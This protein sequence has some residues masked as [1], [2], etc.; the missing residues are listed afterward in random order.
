[1]AMPNDAGEH[2][3]EPAAAGNLST[4]A[5]PSSEPAAPSSS[6]RPAEEGITPE[7]TGASSA[8]PSPG[9]PRAAVLTSRPDERIGASGPDTVDAARPRARAGGRRFALLAAGLTLAAAI[10]AIA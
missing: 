1:M 9:L 6:V 5:A 2:H 10:G 7:A 3:G 4:D 8:T